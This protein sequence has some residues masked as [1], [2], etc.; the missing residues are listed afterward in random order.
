MSTPNQSD[1]ERSSCLI[2]ERDSAIKMAEKSRKHF[3]QIA[4]LNGIVLETEIEVFP[5]IHLVP[6]PSSLGKRG[7]EI[8]RYISERAPAAGGI[9]YF[10]HKTQLI[11]DSS[12]ASEFN[13]EQFFQALSLACNSAV[14]IA[15]LLSVRKDEEPFSLV[16]YAGPTVTHLPRDAAKNSDIEEAKRLYERL[17]NLDSDV[18]RK[19]YIPINRWIKSHA[20]QNGMFNRMIDPEI[21]PEDIPCSSTTRDV[22]KIIDLNIAFESLYLASISKLSHHLSNRASEYLAES[23]DEQEELK[24][25][26]KEIYN[27][28]SKAVHE[29]ALPVKDVKVGKESVTPSEFVKRTQDLCRRSIL[30]ILKDPYPRVILNLGKEYLK[31]LLENGRKLRKCKA[32][33]KCRFRFTDSDH[34]QLHA[35]IPPDGISKSGYVKEVWVEYVTE[36]VEIDNQP[37]DLMTPEAHDT[38]Q[39]IQEFMLDS[40]N[41]IKLLPD[42]NKIQ[43]FTLDSDN[44]MKLLPNPDEI[45]VKYFQDQKDSNERL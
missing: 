11:I 21:L 37:Y 25:M 15:T 33:L 23:Q 18:R 38:K 40:D 9:E 10:F 36:S 19:L 24:E 7:K 4:L 13:S 32:Y 26:F 5:G 35:M 44:V 17:E 27:W 20:E 8:P 45:V 3:Q 16:P 2:D 1:C 31:P 30:K 29:G 6:F 42:P 43:E 28:R 12:Q 39:R 22:D 34:C 41:V 14:Q